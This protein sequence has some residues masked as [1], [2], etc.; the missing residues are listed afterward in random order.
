MHLKYVGPKPIVDNHGV[1]FDKS[2]PD[3]YIFIHAT[4]EILELIEGCVK[5]NKCIIY[6]DESQIIDLTDW[7]GLDFSASEIQSLVQKHCNGNIETI[8]ERKEARVDELIKQLKQEVEENTLLEADDKLAWLNNIDIMTPYYKQFVEN[9]VVYECLLEMFAD[10]IYHKK[11]KE[12]IFNLGKNYGFVFSYLQNVLSE[13]KP[14]LDSS[15]QMEVKNGKTVGHFYI[16][17][18][19]KADI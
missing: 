11:I 17:H 8:I 15:M 12:I 10:D 7:D 3:R 9:E 4:L 16:T 1:D 19:K 2:E 18:P 14:P 6:H 13:H 5:Q